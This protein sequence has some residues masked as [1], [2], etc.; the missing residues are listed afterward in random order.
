MS[1]DRPL[2]GEKRGPDAAS[3]FAYFD[4][5]WYVHPEA[6]TFLKPTGMDTFL[7]LPRVAPFIRL[8]WD[9][10]LNEKDAYSLLSDKRDSFRLALD[11]ENALDKAQAADR[12]KKPRPMGKGPVLLNAT[13]RALFQLWWP[14]LIMQLGW[15]TMETGARQANKLC[16][17]SLN[18]ATGSCGV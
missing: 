11:F 5:S 8:A 2:N 3:P 13:T 18:W 12:L 9:R 17:D 16:G 7:W 6:L 14:T 15:A 1:V 4:Y 10:E